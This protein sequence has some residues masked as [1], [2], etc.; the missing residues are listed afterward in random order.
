MALALACVHIIDGGAA[1][2]LLAHCVTHG[3]FVHR[4]TRTQGMGHNNKSVCVVRVCARLMQ[5]STEEQE[6]WLLLLS[7]SAMEVCSCH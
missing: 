6:H 4:A 2:V 3:V 1:F 7:P 5:H